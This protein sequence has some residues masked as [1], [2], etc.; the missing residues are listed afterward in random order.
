MELM[1]PAGRGTD[2]GKGVQSK[3]GGGKKPWLCG[4]E[5]Y[6]VEEK[7]WEGDETN[8]GGWARGRKGQALRDPQLKRSVFLW[9]C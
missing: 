1:V 8:I 2:I 9:F 3:G 5:K 6:L 7:D 4:G